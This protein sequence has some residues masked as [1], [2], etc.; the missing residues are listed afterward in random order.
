MDAR[1]K[2]LTSFGIQG[3]E[4]YYSGFTHRLRRENLAFAEKYDLYVTAGSDYHGKNKIV[5]LGDTDLPAREERAEGF[6]RFL[7][8]VLPEK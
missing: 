6:M 5:V 4:A 8:R 7:A 1:L 3:L 2:R